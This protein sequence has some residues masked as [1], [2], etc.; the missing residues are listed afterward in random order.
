[1]E[2]D[3]TSVPWNFTIFPSQQFKND[4]GAA[5]LEYCSGNMNWDEVQSIVI[6]RW[7]EEKALAAQE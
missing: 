5:L 4:F 3:K 7:A 1:M 6:K 2:G